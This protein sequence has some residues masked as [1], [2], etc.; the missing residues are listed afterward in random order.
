MGL[1]HK[2]V[3]SFKIQELKG[4]IGIKASNALSY[5]PPIEA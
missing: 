3:C 2:Q 1:S 5:F 4:L